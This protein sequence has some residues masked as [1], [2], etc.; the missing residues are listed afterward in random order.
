MSR[1]ELPEET[2][3]KPAPFEYVAPDSLEQAASLAAQHGADAK[4]LAGGQSLIPAM[5]FRVVQPAMLI[6]LN[7][8]AELRYVRPEADGSLAIGAM[9]TQHELET[10]S[11]VA[12]RTPLLFETLPYIAHPQIRNRGTI[13]G[14]LVHADPAAELPVIALA[15]G[16][17]LKARSVEGERWI[18]V[19]DF[20]RGMFVTDLSEQEILTEIVLPPLPRRTG[21]SFMEAS[22]RRGDYAMMGLAAMVSLNDDGACNAARLVYLNA[23]DGPIEASQAADALTG[24]KPEATTFDEAAAIASEKEIDPLGNVHASIAFQRHLARILTRRALQQAFA[25]ASGR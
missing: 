10:N 3:M 12:D 20:F 4:L 22:R 17:R 1:S 25:R 6:D 23:G 18:E 2:I 15:C 19:G 5:N 7:R 24:K 16:A 21:W 14:S 9:T 8:I 11:L 13:G